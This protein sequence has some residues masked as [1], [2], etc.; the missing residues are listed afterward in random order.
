MIDHRRR[1]Q[2]IAFAPSVRRYPVDTVLRMLPNRRG[3]GTRSRRIHALDFGQARVC[4]QLQWHA[5]DTR[6]TRLKGVAKG[7]RNAKNSIMI[8]FRLSSFHSYYVHTRYRLC[9]SRFAH[10]LSTH[11]EPHTHFSQFSQKPHLFMI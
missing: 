1:S 2:A 10:T 9:H 4:G 3:V 5:W 7:R 8:I 6:N 11:F